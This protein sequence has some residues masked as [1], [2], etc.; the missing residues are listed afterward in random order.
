MLRCEIGNHNDGV[1]LTPARAA[2]R[3]KRRMAFAGSRTRVCP[4]FGGV[5]TRAEPELVLP[6]IQIDRQPT[7]EHHAARMPAIDHGQ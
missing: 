7:D 3:P 4:V 2:I 6:L 1:Y 5:E